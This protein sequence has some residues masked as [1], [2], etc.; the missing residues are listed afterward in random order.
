MAN[1]MIKA[2]PLSIWMWCFPEELPEEACLQAPLYVIPVEGARPSM[3]ML[4]LGG[5]RGECFRA[6]FFATSWVCP[7]LDVRVFVGVTTDPGRYHVV[8]NSSS[9]VREA[10]LGAHDSLCDVI[11]MLLGAHGLLC[12]VIVM[13]VHRRSDFRPGLRCTPILKSP[14]QKF[15]VIP[16]VGLFDG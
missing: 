11:V 5:H 1:A 10:L 7:E 3:Y 6:T 16:F 4:F 2:P 9:C 14:P 8:S 15:G 12:D 13:G